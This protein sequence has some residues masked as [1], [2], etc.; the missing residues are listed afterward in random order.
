MVWKKD[1]KELRFTQAMK[2]DF[3]LKGSQ[4]GCII[5][6]PNPKKDAEIKVEIVFTEWLFFAKLRNSDE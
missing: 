2:H 3:K 6:N 5:R 1:D 4:A